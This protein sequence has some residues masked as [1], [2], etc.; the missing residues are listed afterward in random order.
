MK[1]LGYYGKK[2]RNE[3]NEKLRNMID[4]HPK[5]VC[6]KAEDLAFSPCIA[7]I[8]GKSSGLERI[9]LSSVTISLASL[10]NKPWNLLLIHWSETDHHA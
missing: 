3:K 8:G 10:C 6:W 7:G 1:K 5:G 9:L 4:S 2:G